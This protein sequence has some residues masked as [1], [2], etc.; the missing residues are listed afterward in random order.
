MANPLIDPKSLPVYAQRDKI[1]KA[2]EEHQV[3]VVESPTGSGKT[4]QLPI[5]LHEAGYDTS[6]VIGITQ[7]RRIA[8]VSVAD[9]IQNQVGANSPGFVAY[10][11]RFDD[12]TDKTTRIK[13]MTD[14]ILLQ[15]LKADPLLSQY[16]VIMVDEAHERSLNIDFILGLLKRV[17]EVRKEFKV[18]VSSA[19]INAEVFSQYFSSCPVVR[20]ETKTFPVQ[21]LYAPPAPELEGTEAII[22]KTQ[23]IVE[24][25]IR[26]EREGDILIFLS[27]EKLIKD[28]ITSLYGSSVAKKLHII[29]LY[30]RLSKEEQ[31][32]VFPPAPRGKVKVVVSTNIAET[33]ITINGI[34]TIIDSGLAKIN[35]YSP[36]TYT[37]SL[38]EKPISKASANQR[39]G[40]AG[41]TQPG[42]CYRLY[43]KKEFDSRPL[44]TMEEIYRTDL[45]EVVLR[46]SE[47]GIRDFTAFDFISNPGKPG[48]ASA[49]DTLVLLDALTPENEL[50]SIGKMMAEFPLL[51]RHSRILVEAIT[52][53]P[54]V[55]QETL[56]A[57][58][59]LTT[60]HPF[61]LPQGEEMEAR[62]AHHA[63]REPGGDFHSYLKLFNSYI[64]ATKK[65]RFCE[66]YYLDQQTMDEIVHINDQLTQITSSLGVPITGGG[67]VKAFLCCIAR[68]MIQFVCIKSG[69]S[70]YRSLTAES[71]EIHPGSV[72]FRDTPEIIVAGE[73]VK[74][75]RMFARSVSP[76]KREWLDEISPSLA[77]SLLPRN[78]GA[79]TVAAR[80]LKST[81]RSRTTS[82]TQTD[83][84]L[85]ISL[86]G[87][88]RTLE[89]IKG[90]KKQLLL[91]YDE[92]RRLVKNPNFSVPSHLSQIRVV[93]K[94]GKYSLFSGERLETLFAVLD[95]FNPERDILAK[96]GKKEDLHLLGDGKEL[97][98]QV[99]KIGKL[100]PLKKKDTKLGYLCLFTNGQGI[101]WLKPVDSLSTM[102]SESLGSLEA[103][104]DDSQIGNEKS[105]RNQLNKQFRWLTQLLEKL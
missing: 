68:G 55:L 25:I 45:S 26:E 40:R 90:G 75:S 15:E 87:K 73:V 8:A 102:V 34:T 17:L 86:G 58:S 7:P 5:I 28:T 88:I 39:L 22:R 83:S 49:V 6:G 98:K 53:Y 13:V 61:L 52:R 19:T 93:V 12:R 89:L 92:C 44:F 82:A 97:T 47:L 4:T 3:I 66:Q 29:P 43:S 41:R 72:L 31:D 32:L 11:M 79:G 48:I 69:R 99:A 62:K 21:T 9:Y 96:G 20:I 65:D 27:G 38:V 76:L 24:H 64:N 37:S 67:S 80:D 78:Q 10:K 18:I 1:L 77:Q 103:L 70:S 36:R 30:G 84:G 50:S 54:E 42:S 56:V 16:S 23:E 95:E 105:V 60:S 57:T 101:Y 35:F 59:F 81:K 14:G 91:T 71:I 63:F 51:P 85:Q 2:L 94:Y 33:S 100:V 104:T 46:M 74:T